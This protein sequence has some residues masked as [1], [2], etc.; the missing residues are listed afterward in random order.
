MKIAGSGFAKNKEKTVMSRLR[1]SKPQKETGLSH[2]LLHCLGVYLF[3]VTC[4]AP[5]Q[6]LVCCAIHNVYAPGWRELFMEMR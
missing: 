6:G 2:F 5:G 1:A 3:V 4:L